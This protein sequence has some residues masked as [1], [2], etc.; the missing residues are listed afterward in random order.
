MSENE[1]LNVWLNA[2]NG[3]LDIIVGT[4]SSIFLPFKNLK[5]IIIDEEHDLSLKQQEKFKYHARDLSIIRAKN[6]NLPIILGSATPSFESLYN[7]KIK[8]YKHL[9]LRKRFFSP[10]LPKIILVDLNKDIP[11]EGLSSELKKQIQQ[12]IN[13]K[14]QTLLFI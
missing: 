3:Y 14:E 13:N 8:K 5:A 2:K 11:D 4:R 10:T 7:C 1:K 12:Q 6:N 9:E